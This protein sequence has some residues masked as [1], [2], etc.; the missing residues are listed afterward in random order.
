MGE[1]LSLIPQITAPITTGFRDVSFTYDPADPPCPIGGARFG[2]DLAGR[3][4][5]HDMEVREDVIT[6]TSAVLDGGDLEVVG[7]PVVTL[8]LSADSPSCDI[9]LRLCDVEPNGRS[10][11]VCDGFARVGGVGGTPSSSTKGMPKVSRRPVQRRAS[12]DM[13]PQEPVKRRG[14][15]SMILTPEKS[16]GDQESKE[17]IEPLALE[18]VMYPT[19][20]VFRRGNRVRLCIA[21]GAFPMFS[22][23]LGY[24]ESA[25]S[26]QDMRK[27]NITLLEPSLAPQHLASIGASLQLPVLGGEDQLL[28]ALNA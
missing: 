3:V 19:A 13:M 27:Q 7:R 6:F 11:L 16:G 10:L 8:L 20:A 26:A 22:R 21:G 2:F 18:V 9:F 1:H 14:S 12:M 4:C 15:S 24:G 28:S 23:N 17:S 5:N 25:E